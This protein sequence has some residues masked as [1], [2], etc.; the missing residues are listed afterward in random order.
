[1]NIERTGESGSALIWVILVMTVV[2][3]LG[4]IFVNNYRLELRTAFIFS[5]SKKKDLLGEKISDMTIDASLLKKAANSTRLQKAT[6]NQMLH[7]C[8]YGTGRQGECTRNNTREDGS[9]QI[10]LPVAISAFEQE[11]KSSVECSSEADHSISDCIIGSNNFDNGNIWVS[12]VGLDG[13]F[14][15]AGRCYP[16]ELKI[17]FRPD[18]GLD[19]FGDEKIS[20]VR[21]KNLE[22]AYQLID[23][24]DTVEKCE[25]SELN[26]L[27]P[28]GT[29]PEQ[30]EFLSVPRT[31]ISGDSCNPGAILVGI[32]PGTDGNSMCECKFPYGTTGRQNENGVICERISEICPSGSIEIGKSKNGSPVCKPVEYVTTS[33]DMAFEFGTD[34]SDAG[35][36]CQ[37]N[38][39]LS[40]FNLSCKGKAEARTESY[41]GSSCL[42]F[43]A[44]SK[45]LEGKHYIPGEV[46]GI[47]YRNE[48]QPGPRD[49]CMS[50]SKEIK[51]SNPLGDSYAGKCLGIITGLILGGNLIGPPTVGISDLLLNAFLWD[52]FSSQMLKLG[53]KSS[54]SKEDISVISAPELNLAHTS[55]P[56]GYTPLRE[57]HGGKPKVS[58]NTNT[59]LS[60]PEHSKIQM[61]RKKFRNYASKHQ[62][63]K[64]ITDKDSW[65]EPQSLDKDIEAEYIL[66]R[67]SLAA[68]SIAAK[69]AGLFGFIVAG[70]AAALI[71]STH[72]EIKSSC[73]PVSAPEIEC[74]LDSRCNYLD[75][76][77]M[78]EYLN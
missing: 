19:E 6:G 57:G 17:Y 73:Y 67:A 13:S 4:N 46:P 29:F 37:Q 16:F 45:L 7:Q 63:E 30:P 22:I 70:V 53:S 41:E 50:K 60:N 24:S 43:Y 38:G 52:L 47:F 28:M 21:A 66:I 14:A 55:R 77:K 48:E 51:L 9:F 76:G 31:M 5:Q 35:I 34:F 1:M 78:D 11:E 40:D 44:N 36:N 71:A 10:S 8:I 74:T 23:Q 26:L 69:V 15:K 18:C 68:A 61:S 49:M 3:I 56:V 64:K 39:W 62:I 2:S 59:P 72:V 12:G 27:R 58:V 20:C 25:N 42:F 54:V 32:S 65:I 75:E 33:E